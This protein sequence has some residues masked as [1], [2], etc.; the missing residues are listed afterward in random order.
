MIHALDLKRHIIIVPNVAQRHQNG[1]YLLLSILNTHIPPSTVLE[2]RTKH[3][4]L[5]MQTPCRIRTLD[6]RL[7]IIHDFHWHCVQCTDFENY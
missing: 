7:I 4:I 2:H 5:P 1:P 6:V 3:I